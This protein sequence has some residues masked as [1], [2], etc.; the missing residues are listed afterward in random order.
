METEELIGLLFLFLY[1]GFSVA[2]IYP[3]AITFVLLYIW[4][5]PLLIW[6]IGTT[7]RRRRKN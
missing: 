3:Q 1:I 5:M 6:I 2:A 4:A 7:K